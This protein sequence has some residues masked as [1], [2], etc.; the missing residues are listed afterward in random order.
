MNKRYL[1][2]LGMLSLFLTQC[3]YTRFAKMQ[4]LPNKKQLSTSD[5]KI[6]VNSKPKKSYTTVGLLEGH[7]GWIASKG[8]VFEKMRERAA[9]EGAEAIINMRTSRQIHVNVGFE[10]RS[11]DVSS[12]TIYYGDAIIFIAD[13]DSDEIQTGS[14]TSEELMRR[15]PDIHVGEDGVKARIPTN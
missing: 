5:V 2:I 1:L 6:F 3:T 8:K 11:A 9:K 12:D 7:P 4:D 13:K 14:S 15:D 10:T